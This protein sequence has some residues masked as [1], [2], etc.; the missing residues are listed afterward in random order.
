M[1]NHENTEE[2]EFFHI[3]HGVGL[4]LGEVKISNC[5]PIIVGIY[6]TKP[7]ALPELV[8]LDL[9][10]GSLA[11]VRVE[12]SPAELNYRSLNKR[13]PIVHAPNSYCRS[14]FNE[15]LH[16]AFQACLERRKPTKI[17]DEFDLVPIGRLFKTPGLHRLDD[18]SLC[19]VEGE[20]VIGYPDYNYYIT[21]DT[22]RF[23]IRA[24]IENPL[25]TLF[26]ILR[27]QPSPV[28]LTVAF[29][30][31]SLV[32]S[33]VIDG[34]IDLQ[35]VLYIAGP[36]GTG[37]T[38]LAQ[39]AAGFIVDTQDSRNNP[40]L[41]YGAGG[42]WAGIRDAMAA[43]RDL[44]MI[45]DDLCLSASKQTVRKRQHL[46]A[47]TVR[48]AAN[49]AKIVKKSRNGAQ[50]EIECQAGV[51]LTAEFALENASDLTRCII[52]QVKKPLGLPPAFSA[53]LMGS[54]A[55]LYLQYFV[56]HADSAL[57]RL[58]DNLQETDVDAL[59]DCEEA[60]VRTNLITLRWALD[61][62]FHAAAEQGEDLTDQHLLYTKFDDALRDAV[63]AVNEELQRVRSNTPDG[64]LAYILLR[65]VENGDFRLI[66]N[67]EKI[68][69]LRKKDGIWFKNDLCLRSMPLETYVRQ[70]NGFHDWNLG[71]ITSEL[72]RYSA[73][74][75]QE[76]GTCQVK[77]SK[78]EGIPRVYR[79]RMAALEEYAEAY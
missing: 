33:A 69:K 37:K 45:V 42:T 23:R 26:R 1:R 36:Q 71:D 35:A 79:I 74:C 72:K 8:V 52:A 47:Q 62:L 41:F 51:I 20:D 34:G 7:D 17:D 18:G 66:K 21:P 64:N 29:S 75:I 65:A 39:R 60:R 61:S 63:D 12:V 32:R 54:V 78:A 55:K 11:P 67:E 31:L 68:D 40:A 25:D 5:A 3:M 10:I 24:G 13:F 2:Q 44:P 22:A 49:A 53:E 27:N 4:M 73:L 6:A 38:T 56:E 48:E 43:H 19:A 59:E 28:F 16:D 57:Q 15:Y 14:L 77:I 46:A 70:Q 76:E 30:L 58:R 9:N 50:I